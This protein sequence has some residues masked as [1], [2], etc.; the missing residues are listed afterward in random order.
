MK[1]VNVYEAKTHLSKL[2]E[3]AQQG[4]SVVIAKA[5]RP[6]AELRPY[7]R[8][9]NAVKFGLLKGEIKIHADVVGPDQEVVAQFE[10]SKVLP[11][12][13]I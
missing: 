13:S 5:G 12:E 3:D 4:H 10:G 2:L 11:D 6:V 9:D 7:V 8:K 1:V